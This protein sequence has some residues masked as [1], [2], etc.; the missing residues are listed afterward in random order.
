MPESV[1]WVRHRTKEGARWSPVTP[2][3]SVT[4]AGAE[5]AIESMDPFGPVNQNELDV[6]PPANPT[7]VVALAKNRKSADNSPLV[8]LKT[9]S[10]VI[11]KGEPI[12]LPEERRQAWSEVEVAAVIGRTAKNVSVSEA[13]ECIRGYTIANDVTMKNP[14]GRDL[15]LARGKALDTF[16]PVGPHLVTD[17]DTSD[18]E[19]KTIVNGEVTLR[20]STKKRMMDEMQAIAEISSLMTLEPGDLVLTG[21][22]ASPR[23]SI[24]KPGDVTTVEI[25][26][27]GTLTNPVETE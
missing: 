25:E 26:K 23:D 15:H 9:P 17:L 21:A 2:N 1:K 13:S 27:L 4:E 14:T 18:L 24:I 16:C 22:P 19:V 20:T 8:F 10:S 3:E 7:R 12:R 5:P 11:A 6:L